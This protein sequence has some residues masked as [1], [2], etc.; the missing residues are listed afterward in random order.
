MFFKHKNSPLRKTISSPTSFLLAHS[1]ISSYQAADVSK[2]IFYFL[3]QII[4]KHQ[5]DLVQS[6]AGHVV[7][8]RLSFGWSEQDNHQKVLENERSQLQRAAELAFP[9]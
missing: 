2:A 3:F 9:C 1:N 7:G 4:W 5:L 8:L 6:T